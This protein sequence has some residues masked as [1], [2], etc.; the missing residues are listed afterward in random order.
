MR[1][2]FVI[3][4]VL[5]GGA[6]L[7]VIG[8]MVFV[9]VFP[10]LSEVKNGSDLDE[11]A[12]IYLEDHDLIQEGEVVL[13]YFDHTLS[14]DGTEASILTD[15]RIIYHCNNWFCKGDAETRPQKFPTDAILLRGIVDIRHRIG[16]WADDLFSG[17]IIL[18][19]SDDGR[20]M[21]IKIDAD[22]FGPSFVQTLITTWRLA[23]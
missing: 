1:K 18:I 3:L 7:G 14:D 6:I 23:I 22:V 12:I 9:F 10:T 2:W 17:D 11:Y 5:I 15:K 16:T 13:L 4:G 19:I 8:L 20:E 21:L